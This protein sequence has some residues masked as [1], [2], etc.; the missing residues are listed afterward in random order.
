MECSHDKIAE[1][2]YDQYM[3]GKTKVVREYESDAFGGG[4][5]FNQ[6]KLKLSLPNKWFKMCVMVRKQTD[7]TADFWIDKWNTKVDSDLAHKILQIENRKLRKELA[8]K[9]MVEKENNLRG[10]CADL[11]LGEKL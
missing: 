1:Y 10:L 7:E 4:P 5:R 3:Q 6:L 2:V 9:K 11:G 8:D